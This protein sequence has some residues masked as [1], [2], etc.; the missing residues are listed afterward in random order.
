MKAEAERK[1]IVKRALAMLHGGQ[2]SDQPSQTDAIDTVDAKP[3]TPTPETLAVSILAEN[4]PDEVDS[5]LR[6]WSELFGMRLNPER[7]RDQLEMLREWPGQWTSIRN[8]TTK[9]PLGG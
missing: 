9:G 2:I 7:V 4:G 3:E 1:E 5:I 6:V 8:R